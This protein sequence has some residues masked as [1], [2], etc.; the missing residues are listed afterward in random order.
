MLAPSVRVG[1]V[2]VGPVRVGRD[3]VVLSEFLLV[4]D[5]IL[6]VA[7]V[8]FFLSFFRF[9]SLFSVP[10]LFLDCSCWSLLSGWSFSVLLCLLGLCLL[11][12]SFTV[13]GVFL[14]W[15]VSF[16]VSFGLIN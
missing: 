14:S 11:D 10:E 12:S 16:G 1:P 3:R 4:P 8:L 15:T 2:R 6:P 13:C 7:I 9:F 5:R